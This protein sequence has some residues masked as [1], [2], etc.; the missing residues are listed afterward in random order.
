MIK[1]IAADMDGTL[2][3][4]DHLVSK[5]T[6]KAV[7]EGCNK[8]LRFMVVTGRNFVSALQAL[9]LTKIKCDYIVSSGAQIRDC[10]KN[11]V[12]T[13]YLPE[14]ECEYL[15]HKIKEFHIGMM[16][17]SEMENYMLGTWEEVDEG[18]LN[19]I[20]Y[21]HETASKEDLKKTELYRLMWE[22][23]KV[24]S[25]YEEMKEKGDP[26]TKLFLVSEDIELLATIQKEIEEN[27]VLAVSSSFKYNL[28]ITDYKAQKGPVLK[29]YI[30]S[31]GYS[32]DEVLVV[33]D[34]LN[35]MSM[36]EMKFGATVAMANAD[37]EIKKVA[38]YETKSNEEDGV[39]YII[40]EIIK[41]YDL[42]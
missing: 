28:E 35:D 14:Q 6:E 20:K 9:E 2:L 15:Y 31:L 21:F 32:M 26:I 18:I 5:T 13:I 11:I 22:K 42:N 3:G 30:E 36:M 27:K 7:I 19:Y 39:A 37:E 10:N 25:S 12:S 41:K 40:N 1:V 24:F 38:K 33:G 16:F 17:C 23:T 4:S 8:G 34:S 29:E